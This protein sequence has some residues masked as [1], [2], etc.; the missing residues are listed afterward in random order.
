MTGSPESGFHGKIALDIRDSE[1]DW[2]PYAA[3]TAPEGAPNVLYLVWDDTGIATWD[4]FGGLVQMP[5]M[6]RIAERGVRLSQFHTTALCSPTRA[7]LLTGRNATTV[8]MATIEEFTDGF[9]NCS[10]RIPFDTALLS[11]VLAEKGWNTYCVGKWHLTPLEESNLAAT[12]RHWPLS[13]GFERFYGFMG[14]ETDQWYPDLVYDNHP[15]EPPATPE[16]GYHLSKDIADKTIEFIR[17]AKVI[18]PDKPWFS[19][20]CPGAGHAPH[21]VFKEWADKYAG[22]FDMGYELY[23][24][25]VLENQ[26][27]LGIVPSDTELSPVNPYLDVKGP[28][29]EPWP[30]QDTVRPWDSLN[31]EEK[32]LFSRMAE[33]FAGFLS[34]TDDQI[35][36]VLDYLEDSGQLDNTIIV[37]IS[38]NG[39]SGEGGPNGSV[40]EVKFFNG[41]IDTVEESLR[42]YDNLGGTETY[43]HYPIGWAMAFNTPYKLYKRYASHE[44]GIADTAIISW[45]N[46]IAAHGEVRDTYVNVSDITPTIYDLLGITPPDTVK[47]IAQ[48]PLDGISFT[49]ALKDPTA[50]TAKDTQFYTML[51]TRGIWHKGWFANTVHAATPS[52]WSHFDKDRWELFHIESDRSQCR[53]LAEAHPKKLEELKQLW[54]DEAAKYNGLPLAD[55]NILETLTRWRPYLVGERKSF[56]YYPNTAALGIGAAVDIRGQSFAVLAEVTTDTGAE[57]V[58]FKQGGAHG[59]HVLFIQDGKLHYIYNFMGEKEQKVSSTGAVPLGAHVLG[60]RFVKTGTVAGSHTPVGDVTLFIDG[61]AVGSLGAVEIHPGTFGLAGAS[62]SI[63][64]NSGSA[65]SSDYKAPYAFTGGTIAQVVVDISGEPYE[66]LEKKLAIAF[67]KD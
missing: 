26:K 67:A 5:A 21:H 48:K 20:V 29:G 46:G 58:I 4:C 51:G 60:A 57:G 43:N 24:E 65:V 42:F 32:R 52:G 17:D 54:F 18:A 33:V 11:E 6:S 45:P 28:N 61:H 19:Y 12:K 10:G 63:G 2:T 25:I 36:R 23:R 1:P 56:I 34:Y 15:V 37:V 13:R 8:G 22:K 38:D 9:P 50:D 47:G 49:A 64:R 3:P 44:G 62:L 41:Y 39:A 55:L 40:N 14:G 7:S 59:G 66:N 27:K 53:D 31:D 16:D 35:G 30:L